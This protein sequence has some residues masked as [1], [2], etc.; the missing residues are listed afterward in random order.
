MVFV[1]ADGTGVR[2]YDTKKNKAAG[3][4]GISGSG[5]DAL[6]ALVL[7]F[8]DPIE[9][10]SLQIGLNDY[11]YS[12]TKE[13]DKKASTCGYLDDDMA[14]ILEDSDGNTSTIA[15]SVLEGL[16][17][18]T[19]GFDEPLIDLSN[20]A[21]SSYLSG[22]IDIVTATVWAQPGGHFFVRSVSFNILE[23]TGPDPSDV[24]APLGIGL[25]GL[26]LGGLGYAVR[27]RR[28]A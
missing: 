26:G 12:C 5:G 13:K 16:F 27:R 21:L 1:G 15:G 22:L 14:L 11:G 8:T 4:N 25:L 3:S 7:M 9:A 24:P 10:A 23:D 2:A 18:T 6:E 20:A 17:P 19:E 28:T